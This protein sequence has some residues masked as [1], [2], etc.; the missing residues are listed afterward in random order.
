L[1]SNQINRQSGQFFRE[2]QDAANIPVGIARD[3]APVNRICELA[4]RYGA[5]T[6]IDE[7]HSAGMYGRGGAGIAAREGPCTASTWDFPSC[8]GQPGNGA[9]VLRNGAEAGA[10]LEFK[11]D[12]L[13]I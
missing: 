3:I 9:A 7:V 13:R 10:D 6:Y 5:M 1:S 2:G 4:K 8:S 12:S 11:P